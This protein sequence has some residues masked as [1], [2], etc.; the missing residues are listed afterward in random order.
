M[1][2]DKFKNCNETNMFVEKQ[3]IGKYKALL[4]PAQL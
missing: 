3:K 2:H 1:N 4:M